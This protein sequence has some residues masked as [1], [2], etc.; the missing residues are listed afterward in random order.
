MLMLYTS[1]CESGGTNWHRIFKFIMVGVVISQVT[2]IGVVA[3]KVG[4]EMGPFLL[5]LPVISYLF[6]SH[7]DGLYGHTV[8]SKLVAREVARR[9]DKTSKSVDQHWS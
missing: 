4:V 3:V 5:P 2:V 9:T 8:S 7:F 6:F 1:L